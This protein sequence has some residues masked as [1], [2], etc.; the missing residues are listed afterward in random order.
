MEPVLFV[1]MAPLL[2]AAIHKNRSPLPACAAL[3][4]DSL[5]PARNQ[6]RTEQMLKMSMMT[7]TAALI[8]AG[9]IAT[10][11]TA[12][13]K[14]KSAAPATDHSMPK[15]PTEIRLTFSEGVIPKFS[16]LELKGDGGKSVATGQAA[17]DP[18]DNKQ[19]IVPLKAALAPGDYTVTWHAVSED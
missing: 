11:A 17:L 19:L 4:S 7:A 5:H 6:E 1:R 13:P 8:A 9:L 14:L 12:H 16:G 10:S 2:V 3:R 18:K 15:S